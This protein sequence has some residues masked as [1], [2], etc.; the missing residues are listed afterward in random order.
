MAERR[1][2]EVLHHRGAACT[3]L[4]MPSIGKRRAGEHVLALK[5]RGCSR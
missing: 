5:Q 3:L 2:D 4:E 1:A